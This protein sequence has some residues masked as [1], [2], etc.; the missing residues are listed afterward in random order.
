MVEEDLEFVT[1][2][3]ETI[4]KS[5][6][7]DNIIN[8]YIEANREGLTKITDF[9]IGSEAYHLAD[10]I[11]S[12]MLEQRENI[13]LNY[14][15][16]MIHYAAGEALDNFGDV[17]GIHRIPS[18][19]S[20]GTVTFTLQSA[21]SVAT[22]IPEGTIVATDDAISFLLDE[23][24]T[25]AAGSLSGS[26][27]VICEQEG[28]YTNVLA[29]TV[30]VIVSDLGVNGLTVTNAEPMSGGQDTEE[31]DLF[32]NRI[33]NAPYN[34]PTG[35]LRW[36]ENVVKSDE[37][38]EMSVAS[39]MALKNVPGQDEDVTLYYKASDIA[40]EVVRPDLN[41]VSPYKVKKAKADLY[42]L[43]QQQSYDLV[44]ITVG[45]EEA[46]E[47]TV[48]PDTATEDGDT[49]HYLYAIVVDDSEKPTDYTFETHV[50]PEVEGV[51]DDYN[52]DSEIGVEFTPDGLASAI[53]ENAN[54]VYRCRIVRYNYTEGS[55]AEY[56]TQTDIDTDKYFVIDDTNLSDRI[57][58]SSFSLDLQVEE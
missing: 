19:P 5:D 20:E 30:I 6:Y 2:D 38:C 28:D 44:G 40:G 42:D 35:T 11:A 34:V 12:L 16:S 14:R 21:K 45:L 50:V 17:A 39:I 9:T 4:T 58:E 10:I 47:V 57:V 52:A 53:Q 15:M 31:D 49:I 36:Y 27:E 55:Y 3:G 41:P 43:F 29:G 18:A 54:Y 32:R 26:G 8:E 22:V 13:D 46:S 48:L 7:R 33:L 23:E 24:V 1:F 51:I 56:S 37:D 25:I